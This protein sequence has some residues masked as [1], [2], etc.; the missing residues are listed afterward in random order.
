MKLTLGT[1]IVAFYG[2]GIVNDFGEVIK[3]NH[4]GSVTVMY[5]TGA[6]KTYEEDFIRDDYVD[7]VGSPIGVFVNPYQ[8]A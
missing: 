3:M 4:D 6:V 2:I 8:G 7:P 5:D 1:K